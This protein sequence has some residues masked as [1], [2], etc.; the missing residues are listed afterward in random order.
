MA[1]RY[2]EWILL[3][4]DGFT[5]LQQSKVENRYWGILAT[6]LHI[7]K[8]KMNIITYAKMSTTMYL[9]RSEPIYIRI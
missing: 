6:V 3:T 7:N 9:W 8:K 5:M 4:E 1:Q 2:N